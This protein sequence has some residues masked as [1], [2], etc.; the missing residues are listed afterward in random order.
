MEPISLYMRERIVEAVGEEDSVAAAARR[1][2]V[3]E[4][5]VWNFLRLAER[6]ELEPR[7]HS[8]G[9]SPAL[10]EDDLERLRA[11]VEERPDATL[12][13]LIETCDLDCDDSTV[14]RALA[15]MGL[16]RKRKIARAAERDEVRVR[17]R[18]AEWSREIGEVD[19][20]RLWFLDEMGST[21]KMTRLY[22]RAAA[23]VPVYTDVPYRSWDSLTTLSGIRLGCDD[24][25][26]LT[27]PGGTTTDR[28]L[29]FVE[30]Q[31]G[32]VLEEGQI[33]VA[34]NLAAHKA[35]RVADALAERGV[36]IWFLPPYSPDLNPIERMW[37]KVKT[38]VRG[39][40][41]TTVA[42]LRRA[43]RAAIE[44]VTTSDVRNWIAHSDYLETA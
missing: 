43:L 9:S 6:G 29:E 16:R 28:M 7:P 25:P 21:T 5:T 41:A 12:A 33:V 35:N 38:F 17:K 11:A 36:E 3:S 18:R 26:T 32:D 42:A 44:H 34:D 27:Y 22:G 23:G 8:G 30:G 31:L 4:T 14:S 19:P 13:E 10:D 37:S 2:K 20:A 1:F 24:R 39:A 40:R 15:K